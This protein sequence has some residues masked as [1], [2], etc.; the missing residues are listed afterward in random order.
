MLA[1]WAGWGQVVS[2]IT[3]VGPPG[4]VIALALALV[5]IGLRYLRWQIY[6]EG[7]GHYV[8]F[9]PSFRAFVAGFA[10][11]TTPAGIGEPV[12]RV[13]LLKAF[14]V[15]Y[16]K[17]VAAYIA[18]RMSDLTSILLL[19]TAG[20]YAYPPAVPFV[21]V[22]AAV[23]FVLMFL[24]WSKQV[25]MALAAVAKR[26]ES[27]KLRFLRHGLEV[28]ELCRQCVER[29]ALLKGLIL[30]LLAWIA[31]A[32]AFYCLAHFADN[33][34]PFR[35]A[36]FI[37][38]VSALAGALSFLPGGVGTAEA[39][40]ITLAMVHGMPKADA[41]AITLVHRGVSLWFSV[42]LGLCCYY[43]GAESIPPGAGRNRWPN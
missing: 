28:L 8:P 9:V 27:R 19:A 29:E 22:V 41:V 21:S 40:M 36:I 33:P 2:A 5:N 35:T 7:F 34:I 13:A 11:A 23:V 12:V 26:S 6:L 37:Y 31:M 1:Y 14:S 4:V 38:T 18:E 15:S 30:A 39:A 43:F 17:V 32:S 20:L 10:L 25:A 24:V 42:A 3:Q 16:S